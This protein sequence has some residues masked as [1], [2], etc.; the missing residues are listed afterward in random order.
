MNL[1]DDERRAFMLG[2]AANLAAFAL[3]AVAFGIAKA[4]KS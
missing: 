3:I 2:F 4:A 1:S